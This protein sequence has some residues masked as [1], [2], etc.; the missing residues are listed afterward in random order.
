MA[1]LSS[2]VSHYGRLLICSVCHGIFSKPK[3]LP[4]MHT[5]CKD[6][7]RDFVFSRSYDVVGRFPCPACRQE[8]IIPPSGVDGYRDN[9]YIT[10]ILESLSLGARPSG[11]IALIEG[12]PRDNPSKYSFGCYGNGTLDLTLPVGLAMTKSGYIIVSDKRENR[13]MTFDICGFVRAVFACR[14]KINSIAVSDNDTIFVANSEPGHPLAIEYSLKGVQLRSFGLLNRLE[15][16]HGIAVLESPF[17]LVASAPE[18]STLYLMNGQGKLVQ[19]FSSRGTFGQPYHLVT[20]SKNQVIVSDYLNHCIKVFDCHG[21]LKVKFGSIGIEKGSLC[22]PLGVCVDSSD[23]VI[24]A[25]SGNRVV[26]AFSPTGKFLRVAVD[27]NRRG[28]DVDI[29]Q[30]INVVLSDQFGSLIVLVSG[31]EF[32][33]IQV[34]PYQVPGPQSTEAIKKKSAGGFWV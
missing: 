17:Q 10:S 23:N 22:Q 6:C 14:E 32:A 1:A 5:F 25:D 27:L 24:V 4:C 34:H 20:N 16:T 29:V 26:K 8:V 30:P 13:I 7:L 19:K 31:K 28:S 21:K 33:Q 11:Q 15:S 12:Y 18:T 3:A 9:F 2:N